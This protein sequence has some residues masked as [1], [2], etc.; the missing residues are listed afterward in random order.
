MVNSLIHDLSIV[1]KDL[2]NNYQCF[3]VKIFNLKI[4]E[5]GL[6]H[7]LNCVYTVIQVPIDES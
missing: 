4:I 7:H 2:K 6:C 1:I 3:E 5:F